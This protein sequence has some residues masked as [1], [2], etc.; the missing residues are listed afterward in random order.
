MFRNGYP[1]RM[2]LYHGSNQIVREPRILEPNR[3]MDFG[4]GFY[5]TQ[6]YKQ[7]ERWAGDVRRKRGADH[8]HVS[9]YEYN[10]S[11]RLRVLVFD[12]PTEEWLDFVETNRLKGDSHDYDIAIGPVADEGVYYVLLLYESGAIS[13]EETM[14]RLEAARLDGQV[15]FHTGK[16]LDDIVFMG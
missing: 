14:I 15:L 4:K 1:K 13:C 7:A 8:A 3:Q 16:S 6:S 9:E 5:T 2:R 10:E 12:G 11:G